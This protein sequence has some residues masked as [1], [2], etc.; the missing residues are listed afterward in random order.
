[1]SNPNLNQIYIA[2]PSSIFGNNT[3][4][5]GFDDPYG[6]G[7]DTGITVQD[8]ITQILSNL[9]VRSIVLPLQTISSNTN[10]LA[11]TPYVI[12]TASNVVGTLPLATGSGALIECSSLSTNVGF[13]NII[14]QGSDKIYFTGTPLGGG[15]NLSSNAAYTA[16]LR[17]SGN[18]IWN[19]VSWI[20]AG[21]IILT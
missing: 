6:T 8:F 10:L 11:G 13:F 19:I 1:M 15:T 12:S 2:N 3:L 18:G 20:S 4:I 7:D 21:S 9:P 16:L 5:Y 14:T 17:D